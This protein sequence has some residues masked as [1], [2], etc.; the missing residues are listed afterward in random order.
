MKTEL[1]FSIFPRQLKQEHPG[2]GRGVIGQ[3]V[4]IK[5]TVL[6]VTDKYKRLTQWRVFGKISHV[7]KKSKHPFTAASVA[8]FGVYYVYLSISYSFWS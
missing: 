8:Y 4:L 3:A 2:E 6:F 1:W 7:L 5:V